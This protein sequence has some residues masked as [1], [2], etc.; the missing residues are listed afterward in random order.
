M[1]GGGFAGHRGLAVVT[2][3]GFW[4]VL[5]SSFSRS[6]GSNLPPNAVLIGDATVCATCTYVCMKDSVSS[7]ESCMAK[8]PCKQ[9]GSAYVDNCQLV[10]TMNI[11]DAVAV[12]PNVTEHICPLCET[13]MQAVPADPLIPE[14][15]CDAHY[16]LKFIAEVGFS[17][18]YDSK[19]LCQEAYHES[20]VVG[21]LFGPPSPYEMFSQTCHGSCQSYHRRMEPYLEEL[22]KCNCTFLRDRGVQC[23]PS[24]VAIMCEETGMC[25]DTIDFNTKFC[26]DSACG[27]TQGKE[28][29]SL[30]AQLCH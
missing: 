28:R 10:E 17:D 2:A 21:A 13:R 19:R 23:F 11:T 14:P 25:F 5:L 27:R 8:E 18:L 16:Y 6:S 4:I 9:C 26:D 20:L 12:M 22:L 29:H 30:F 1:H 15:L 7:C 3:I 24:A